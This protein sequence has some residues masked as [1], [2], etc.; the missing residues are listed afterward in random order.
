MP[1]PRAGPAPLSGMTSTRTTTEPGT[2]SRSGYGGHLFTVVLV[3]A[4]MGALAIPSAPSSP[5]G[6][7]PA[8]SVVRPSAAVP[9]VSTEAPATS[10]QQNTPAS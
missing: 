1:Y 6:R 8:T 2:G 7:P 9:V 3:A 5:G 4:W 10:P